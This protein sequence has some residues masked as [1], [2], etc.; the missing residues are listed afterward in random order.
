MGRVIRNQRK[1]RGS[2]FSQ[3]PLDTWLDLATTPTAVLT[4]DHSCQHALEQGPGQ[5]SQPRLCRAP[6]LRARCSPRHHP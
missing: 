3:S 2:I 5:V 6:W 4:Q 1:G